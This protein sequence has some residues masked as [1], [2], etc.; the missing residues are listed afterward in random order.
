[1]NKQKICE[2]VGSQCIGTEVMLKAEFVV[3][4]ALNL[5]EY[6]ISLFCKELIMIC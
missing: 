4:N 2:Y 5:V 6:K 1:M 3:A